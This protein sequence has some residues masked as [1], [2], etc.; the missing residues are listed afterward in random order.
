[1]D[2]LLVTLPARVNLEKYF[3]SGA[4]NVFAISCEKDDIFFALN[5]F[6]RGGI[7]KLWRYI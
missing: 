2:N 4:K 5:H 6:S 3:L 7:S 1:M